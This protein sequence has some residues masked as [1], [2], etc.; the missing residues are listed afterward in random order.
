MRLEQIASHLVSNAIRFGGGRPIDVTVTGDAR[1]GRLVVRDR[2]PGI[3]ADRL[4]RLFERLGAGVDVKQAGGLGVGLWLSSRLAQALGG[5]VTATSTPGEGTEMT[6]EIP[7][8]T[9]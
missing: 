6:L 3:A 7:K 8:V 4:A 5:S 1:R 2:G 9:A